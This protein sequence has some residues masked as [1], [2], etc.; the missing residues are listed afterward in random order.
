MQLRENNIKKYRAEEDQTDFRE[1]QEFWFNKIEDLLSC[2]IS[3]DLES[4]KNIIEITFFIFAKISKRHRI[5]QKNFL[6]INN[7]VITRLRNRGF[8]KQF[9]YHFKME[10]GCFLCKYNKWLWFIFK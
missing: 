6:K 4:L 2:Q 5:V 7:K 10:Y 1:D 9:S 8:C 3:W